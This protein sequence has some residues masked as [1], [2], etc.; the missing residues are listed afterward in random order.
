MNQKWITLIRCKSPLVF[1]FV[2]L[3]V[4]I[5]H[6]QRPLMHIELRRKMHSHETALISIRGGIWMNEWMNQYK[7]YELLIIR[8][9]IP[10][11]YSL[12]MKKKRNCSIGTTQIFANAF[13][14]TILNALNAEYSR[15]VFELGRVVLGQNVF[16]MSSLMDSTS[17]AKQNRIVIHHNRHACP[18]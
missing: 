10:I 8:A 9:N 5:S 7:I 1:H 17:F 12:Q 3:Q 6:R 14:W 15:H 2:F 18:Q 13:E 4:W 16:M 11:N